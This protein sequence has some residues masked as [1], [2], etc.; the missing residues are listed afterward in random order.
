MK[1]KQ[2]ISRPKIISF[3][4]TTL[5]NVL[6]LLKFWSDELGG[7]PGTNIRWSRKP[8]LEAVASFAHTEHLITSF[9][10]VSSIQ[11]I[12]F[13]LRNHRGVKKRE[14][15]CFSFSN[16]W[17]K[18]RAMSSTISWLWLTSVTDN[19]IINSNKPVCYF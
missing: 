5:S 8:Y 10:S 16:L 11:Q 4:K 7:L 14:R 17:I 18:M 2:C 12:N 19:L 13:K 3:I 9:Y 1:S 6:L 15:R